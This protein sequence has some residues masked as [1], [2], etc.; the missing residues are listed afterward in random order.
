MASVGGL[1]ALFAPSPEPPETCL[2][3]Q[4]ELHSRARSRLRWSA[5]HTIA[6]RNGAN[7]R[8]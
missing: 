1:K 2:C 4:R 5:T 3:R 6:Q 7:N 8:W